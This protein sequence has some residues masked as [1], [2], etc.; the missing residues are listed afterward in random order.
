MRGAALFKTVYAWGLRRGETAQLDVRDFTR[1]PGQPAFG[2]CRMLGVRYGKAARGG[3]PRR[4]DVLT[5]FDWSAEVIGQYVE[6]IRPLYGRQDHPALFLTERGR[7]I[8]RG[9]ITDRFAEYR[10]AAGLPSELTPHSF[11][12]SYVTHL[13]ED[14]WDELFTCSQVG[15][16]WASTTAIYTFVSSDYKN[17]AMR[18][19]LDS[20]HGDQLSWTRQG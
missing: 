15:H 2:R 19:A 5:V 1:N 10:D 17:D 4:R 11:W 14:G 6:E 3:S 7:R 12:R 8:S 13:L 18:R 20:A 9:F 16:R